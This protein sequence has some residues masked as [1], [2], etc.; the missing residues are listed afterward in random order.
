[1]SSACFA[2]DYKFGFDSTKQYTLAA[3]AIYTILNGILTIWILF[4][5]KGIIYTGIAPNGDTIAIASSVTKN[6]PVYNLTITIMFSKQETPY[7]TIK[8]SRP[9]TE[10]FDGTGHFM[11]C[12]FQAMII[13]SVP[14]VAELNPGQVPSIRQNE[15]ISIEGT[16]S[17]VNI[18]PA[19]TETGSRMTSRKKGG[20]KQNI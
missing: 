8:V 5:E 18:E 15:E 4:K 12:P 16:S 17:K 9:F 20:K 6:I 2:W 10:W 13:S 1:M 19:A 11:T 14:L 3:V 7:K